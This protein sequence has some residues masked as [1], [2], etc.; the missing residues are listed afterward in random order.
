[1]IRNVVFD[2][3]NVLA[4]VRWAEL[5]MDDLGLDM[6]TTKALSRA[7][8]S[9]PSWSEWDRGYTDEHVMAR[10]I[11]DAP[12]LESD[13]RR[14]FEVLPR[15]CIEYPT[16]LQWVDGLRARG[17][18][19]LLLTNFGRNAFL[20]ADPPFRFVS[21]VDGILASFEVGL[22]KP[23]PAIFHELESRFGIL[24]AETVFL[25][26]TAVNTASADKLGYHTI[27]VKDPIS[28]AL[29]LDEL[30]EKEGA[31]HQ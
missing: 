17:Y 30:L 2:V 5:L 20:H 19:V 24:P 14:L 31:F 27:T 18:R 4:R 12:Q 9:H 26:D 28:A 8:V 23:D 3:G 16:S 7:T 13:I 15:I 22:E 25:D 21:H 29:A 11:A 1:M 6:E 10:F